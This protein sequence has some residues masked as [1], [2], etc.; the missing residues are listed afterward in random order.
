MKLVRRAKAESDRKKAIQF[1]TDQNV[2]AAISQLDEIERQTDL[3]IDQPE[4]DLPGRIDGTREL[5]IS[6]TSFIVIYRVGQK[7]KQVEIL[8]LVRG[9]QKWPPKS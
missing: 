9:A 5:I 4:I 8:R 6:R 7:I 3:L 2:G 1:I